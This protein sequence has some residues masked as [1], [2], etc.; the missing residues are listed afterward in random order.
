MKNHQLVGLADKVK[1]LEK[2]LQDGQ[3]SPEQHE[4]DRRIRRFA[5]ALLRARRRRERISLA[6][7]FSK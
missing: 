4:M 7:S 5:W 3:R 2:K 1:E 6:Q